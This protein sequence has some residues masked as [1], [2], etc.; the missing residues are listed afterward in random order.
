MEDIHL[1]YYND[2]G[3]SFHWKRD[4]SRE[5]FNKVQLVFRDTGFY[6]Y[7][8]EIALFSKQIKNAK[9]LHCSRNFEKCEQGRNILLSTPSRQIDLAV[10]KKELN[11]IDDLVKGTLFQINMD[12]FLKEICK[13]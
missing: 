1:L 8:E 11:M 5:N 9:E 6:L 4:I 10:S 2:Y 12:G 7:P 13:S 3:I